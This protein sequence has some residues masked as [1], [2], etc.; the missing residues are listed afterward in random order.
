MGYVW[1]RGKTRENSHTL[2][3]QRR[4]IFAEWNDSSSYEMDGCGGSRVPYVAGRKRRQNG[5]GRT[6]R[7]NDNVLRTIKGGEGVLYLDRTRNTSARDRRD[8]R[9]FTTA[10]PS[11]TTVTRTTYV[12]VHLVQRFPIEFLG[13]LVP[14]GRI[15]GVQIAHSVNGG[16]IANT[17]DKY[18]LSAGCRKRANSVRITVDAVVYPVNAR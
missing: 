5:V 4:A 17:D 8:A 6:R 3:H 14:F 7:D 10:P 13:F 18:F 16:S 1:R 9:A 15:R 11:R 12:L 2:V